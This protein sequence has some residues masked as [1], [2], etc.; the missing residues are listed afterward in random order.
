MGYSPW[1]HKDSDTTERLTLSLFVFFLLLS[2]LGGP[3]N[4]T[5]VIAPSSLSG[6]SVCVHALVRSLVWLFAAPWTGVAKL[7]VSGVFQARILEC[8][9]IYFSRK[10]S[11]PRD[12][13]CVSCIGV[14]FFFFKPLAPPGKPPI[15]LILLNNLFILFWLY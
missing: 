13:T 3:W 5:C 2:H 12:Q 7:L 14:D 10:S 9:A 8:V 15:Y 1:G 6:T 11:Q 4:I